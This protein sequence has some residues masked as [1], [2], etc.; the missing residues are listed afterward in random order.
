VAFDELRKAE[1]KK[2]TE[3]DD[4]FQLKMLAPHRRFVLVEKEKKLKKDDLK[5][6][7]RLKEINKNILNGWFTCVS[8]SH[9]KRDQINFDTPAQ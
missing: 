2:A 1:F 3:A 9:E 5:M 6:L 8:D 7:D 4:K